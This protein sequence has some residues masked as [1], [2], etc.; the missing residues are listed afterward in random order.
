MLPNEMRANEG[1]DSAENAAQ[2]LADAARPEEVQFYLGKILI[3]KNFSGSPRLCKFLRMVVEFTLAGDSGNLKEYTIA[4]D[5]FERGPE[6]DP[7]VDSIVRVEAQRLRLKLKQYYE[8]AGRVDKVR[9]VFQPGSYVPVF[10]RQTPSPEAGPSADPVL[11]QNTVAVLPFANLS[12]DPEQVLFCEGI[13]EEIVH[14]LTAIPQLRV[15]GMSTALALRSNK[16]GP[17]AACRNHGVGTLI[18]GSVRQGGSVLRISAVATEAATGH[19]VW[20]RS[21]DRE[22]EDIFAVQDEI[23]QEVATALH[24][25][26]RPAAASQSAAAAPQ[27]TLESYRLYL[28]GRHKWDNESSE[29]C[30]AALLDF[31]R[32]ATFCPDYALPYTGI[33]D[34]YQW[35]A[36]MGW[37]R[38]REVHPKARRA[39]LEA[40]RIDPNLAEAYASLAGVL[41]HLEW[42]WPGAATTAA[43]ALELNPSCGFAH[44]ILARVA[45]VAG[46]IED[47]VRGLERALELDPLSARANAEL[48]FAH[49]C[50]GHYNESEH[51]FQ[52]A[53]DLSPRAPLPRFL[54]MMNYVATGRLDDALREVLEEPPSPMNDFLTAMGGFVLARCGH[55]DEALDRLRD[56]R[57]ISQSR[58]V[59]PFSMAILYMGLG[60]HDASLESLAEAVKAHAPRAVSMTL[61]PL[62]QPL[63]ED[64]RFQVLVSALHL[65]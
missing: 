53:S 59:D 25:Q 65:E 5:V 39:A 64:S 17:A 29:R 52:L 12:S 40:L 1:P 62:L 3:S 46:R 26:L 28:S 41:F 58:Y 44:A 51:W 42:D 8:D 20:S 60:D 7:R 2:R 19:T 36:F 55:R 27:P 30:E 4:Q 22:M 15:L 47:S 34:A 16:D 49:F 10:A 43:T 32:A 63:R 13:A 37:R 61:N 38:P 6:Y 18:E 48:G 57:E 21:F 23:A 56:L 24:V 45:L 9:I 54:L 31:Q 33:S 11:D 14:K 50:G 35:M